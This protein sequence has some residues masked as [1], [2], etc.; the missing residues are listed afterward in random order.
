MR[1]DIVLISQ[2]HNSQKMLTCLPITMQ[3]YVFT[4]D[5]PKYTKDVYPSNN[6]KTV[7]KNK[8]VRNDLELP[9]GERSVLFLIF[10]EIYYI[11]HHSRITKLRNNMN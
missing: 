8:N 5:E 10:L 4:K 9:T 1:S 7:K 6:L 2:L 3:R 11:L